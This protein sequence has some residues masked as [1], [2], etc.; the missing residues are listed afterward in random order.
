LRR[1]VDL[2]SEHVSDARSTARL[3]VRRWL[4]ID[5]ALVCSAVQELGRSAIN[6]AAQAVERLDRGVV[7]AGSAN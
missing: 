7:V 3:L 2:K 1:L 4:S 5:N 6:A